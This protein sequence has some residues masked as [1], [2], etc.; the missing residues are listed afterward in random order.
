V[1]VTPI[2][3]SMDNRRTDINALRVYFEKKVD[4][5]MENSSDDDMDGQYLFQLLEVAKLLQNIK[6]GDN[7]ALEKLL[8]IR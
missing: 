5:E 2:D 4:E 1:G 8:H 3:S 7:A 6:L